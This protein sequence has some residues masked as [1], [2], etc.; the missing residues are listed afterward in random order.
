[1]SRQSSR[2][3]SEAAFQLHA[4]GRTWQEI[5]DTLNYQ[6]RQA[7]QQAVKRLHARQ[8]PASPEAVRRSSSESLRILRS[9]LFERVAVAKVKGDD[10]TLIGLHREL[11][12]NIG[13]S[14]KLAGAYAPEEINVNVKQS[15]AA[16]IADARE[17]L[18]AI[19]D[20]EVVG[21]L[22]P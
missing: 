10:Q 20:A 22:E 13:E 7:A 9:I 4:A 6:S 2:A 15:P 17:R 11:T 19:I 12:R 16:I 3:R 14:A 18:L 8:P 1:M 21:E 5:A